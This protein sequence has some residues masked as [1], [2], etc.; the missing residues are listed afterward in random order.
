MVLRENT[1]FQVHFCRKANHFFKAT[2][3][4]IMII[5][6]IRMMMIII[7]YPSVVLSLDG[8]KRNESFL[9]QQE[10]SYGTQQISSRKI[11]EIH[12]VLCFVRNRNF[13]P[14]S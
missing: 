2:M 11:G 9:A 7:G 1:R 14:I 6:I 8:R 13:G 5:I 12:I 10:I 4:I 3:V